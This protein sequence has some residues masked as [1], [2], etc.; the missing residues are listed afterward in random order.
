MNSHV[1]YIHKNGLHYG[2]L[3]KALISIFHIELAKKTRFENTIIMPTTG[4]LK[5]KLIKQE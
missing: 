3:S 2:Y 5:S 4:C 1:K